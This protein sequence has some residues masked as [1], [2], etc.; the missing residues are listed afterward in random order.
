MYIDREEIFKRLDIIVEN[1][2]SI[3]KKIDHLSAIRDCLDGEGILDN[4]DLLTITKLSPRTL[5]RY[6]KKGILPYINQNGKN[7]YRAS[8]V[9]RFIKE[10]L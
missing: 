5:L 3:Q 8:D 4:Q 2:K 10:N 1:Q 6:R 7:L 9:R